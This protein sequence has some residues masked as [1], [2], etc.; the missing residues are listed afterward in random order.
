[1][2]LSYFIALFLTTFI[3]FFSGCG[4]GGGSSGTAD[5]AGVWEGTWSSTSADYDGTVTVELLQDDTEVEGTLLITGSPC[6]STADIDGTV[7]GN[8]ISFSLSGEDDIQFR[9][10]VSGNTIDGT[11]SISTGNCRGD[12]I[13]TLT[14]GIYLSPSNPTLGDTEV[15]NM[16]TA[17]HELPMLVIQLEYADKVFTHNTL[18]WSNKF[19]GDQL[20]QL[21]DYYHEVSYGEFIF[22]K[23]DESYGTENDGIVAVRLNKIHPDSGSSS[24]IHSDLK[25]A[26]LKADE[27]VDF[28]SYDNNGDTAITPNELII[29]FLVAGYEEAAGAGTPSVWAHSSCVSSNNTPVVD[30]VSTMSC[31][32][33]GNYALYGERHQIAIDH[34]APIGIIAHELGHAAFQLPDLYDTIDSKYSGIGYFGIMGYGSWGSTASD[35]DNALYGNTPTHFCAWSKLRISQSKPYGDWG[36]TETISDKTDYDVILTETFSQNYNMVKIPIN[37]NEYFLLENRNNSGYDQGLYGLKG[38]F[39]GGLAIWHID[40]SVIAAKYISNEVNNNV[41]R[42]GVD[43]EDANYANI[44]AGYIDFENPGVGH[45]ANLF[46]DDNK[47]AFNNTTTPN[48]KDYNNSDS[49]ISVESISVRGTVMNAAVSNPN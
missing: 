47:A 49:S 7:S 10:S 40:E 28:S 6:M 43:I 36:E 17:A 8:L 4:G 33:G 31:T 15:A 25:L 29:V 1:M 27:Y 18:T 26:I 13:F 14:K 35:Q 34:D 46:Y 5:V 20:H 48:S 24:S 16:P 9:G 2:K 41:N 45:E 42:K 44:D 38:N 12:G 30:D 21:N 19:F 22:S 3:A 32:D 23:V 11:Y 39:N 37:A